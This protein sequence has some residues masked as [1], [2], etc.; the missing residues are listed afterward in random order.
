MSALVIL[1]PILVYA[2]AVVVVLVWVLVP[3]WLHPSPEEP[4]SALARGSDAGMSK[5]NR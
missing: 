3:M 5:Q 2:G 4:T 1:F